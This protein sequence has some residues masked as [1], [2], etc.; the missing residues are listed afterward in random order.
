MAKNKQEALA[1]LNKRY[2]KTLS[3]LQDK[4]ES[5]MKAV[6]GR[7]DSVNIVFCDNGVYIEYDDKD[8]NW[9]HHKRVFTQLED[10][11][12]AVSWLWKPEDEEC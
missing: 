6:E 5:K 1:D 9:K 4:K 2:N 8:N 3:L 7:T 12:E 11:L 10:A